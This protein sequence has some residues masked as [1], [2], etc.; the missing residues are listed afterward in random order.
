MD[1]VESVRSAKK[2]SGRLAGA[3]DAAHLGNLMGIDSHLIERL[4]NLA[5]HGIV[6]ATGAKRGRSSPILGKG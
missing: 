3:T 6:T 2:I 5:R 4:H 1:T